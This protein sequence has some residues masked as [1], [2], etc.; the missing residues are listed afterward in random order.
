LFAGINV[1]YCTVLSEL[2]QRVQM[3][4]TTGF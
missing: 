4:W 3:T 2:G 1:E